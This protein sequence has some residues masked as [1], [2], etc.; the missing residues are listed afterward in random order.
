VLDAR[1][2]VDAEAC[3]AE[4]LDVRRVRDV[5][6]VAVQVQEHEAPYCLCNLAV[7]VVRLLDDVAAKMWRNA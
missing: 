3:S 6:Q 5:F 1:N 4:A 2:P 7:G